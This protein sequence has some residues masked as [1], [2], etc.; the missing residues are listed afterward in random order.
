MKK[1]FACIICAFLMFS[2][3]SCSSA[4]VVGKWE[5]KADEK[6]GGYNVD[7]FYEFNEDKT[8]S[9]LFSGN[10]TPHTGTYTIQGKE[11]TLFLSDEKL[12]GIVEGDRITFE[13]NGGL[14]RITKIK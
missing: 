12:M 11:L 13:G 8:F 2:L 9:M 14:F 1:T 3:I 6:S 7:V 5:Y 4:S 10:K